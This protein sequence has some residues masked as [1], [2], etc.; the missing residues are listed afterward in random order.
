[1]F[2]NSKL[3]QLRLHV[4]QKGVEGAEAEASSLERTASSVASRIDW[5][6]GNLLGSG[7]FGNVYAA[8]VVGSNELLAGSCA[9]NTL[10]SS[11]QFL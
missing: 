10:W 9:V 1:M 6:R 8:L 11:L 2:T 5:V 7:S 3:S 4:R